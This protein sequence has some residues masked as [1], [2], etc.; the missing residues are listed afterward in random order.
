MQRILTWQKKSL[1]L[2]L[3][4]E[5]PDS[6]NLVADIFTEKSI[7]D[8]E[9]YRSSIFKIIKEKSVDKGNTNT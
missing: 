3:K 2:F 7:I 4:D 8:F 6:R 5:L 9:I 1:D